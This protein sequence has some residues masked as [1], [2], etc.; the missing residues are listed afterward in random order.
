MIYHNILEVVGNTPIIRLQRI[1]QETGAELLVKFEG[2]NVGGS[3]KTRTALA[4]VEDLER[5]G[6]I[7]PGFTLVESTTGNQGI[8][9]AL[10][11]AVKGY[12]AVLVMP[13]S[14]GID[15]QKL[16]RAYGAEIVLTPEGK[17]MEETIRI[18]REVASEIERTR[19]NAVYIKQFDSFSNPGAHK[20]GTAGEILAQTQGRLDAFVAGVGT[21]GTITGVAE[22][23]K[24]AIPTIKVFGVEPYA[25]ALEGFGRKGHH[26]QPGIGDGQHNRFMNRDVIDGWIA[27]HDDDAWEMT[28]RLAKEEGILAGISSGAATWAAVQV[29]LELGAGKR[30][31][32]ILPDTGE[33]Y[34]NYG[35]WD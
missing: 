24:S 31:L 17:D 9:L 20:R 32:A 2:L 33:R 27:V 35:I 13:K 12:H 26:K 4:I 19:P 3:V 8:A 7:S 14:T 21:G 5:E 10:I 29:A 25:A 23:L 22:T 30:I 34:L 15:R 1:G 6:R 18:C 16:I 28:R 11:A